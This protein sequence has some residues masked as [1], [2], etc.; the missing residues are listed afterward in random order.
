MLSFKE[1]GIEERFVELLRKR[2]IKEPTPVQEESI[3]A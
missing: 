3:D 1:L 2:G